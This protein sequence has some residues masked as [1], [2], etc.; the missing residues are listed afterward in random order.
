MLALQYLTGGG[1]SERFNLG[2]GEGFS[3]QQVIDSVEKVTGRKVKVVDGPR[4]DGDP[5]RL[6]ADSRRA[7]AQL[8]WEPV[9]PDLES[10]VQH[11]W[12]WECR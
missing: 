11:A 2:N 9:Y 12:A 10:I 6:V 1:A 3:V 7:R 4:R 5:A 8:G